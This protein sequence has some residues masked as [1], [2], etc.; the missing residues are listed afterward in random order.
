MKI[1]GDKTLI[2]FSDEMKAAYKKKEQALGKVNKARG[3]FNKETD[4]R[5]IIR[6]FWC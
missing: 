2:Q 5:G 1:I 6:V 3:K 4:R